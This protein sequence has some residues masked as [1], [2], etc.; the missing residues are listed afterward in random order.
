M[1]VETLRPVSGF[2]TGL[3]LFPDTGEANW[4]DV[5]EVTPDDDTTYV[6]KGA[7]AATA[8]D[9][10]N[11]SNSGVGA[12]VITNVRVY[13]RVKLEDDEEFE[14][15]GEI[16]IATHSTSYSSGA[17]TQSNVWATRYYD[18]AINPNTS[19][20]WTWVEIDALRAGVLLTSI[21]GAEDILKAYCTQFYVVVTYEP[22]PPKL[23]RFEKY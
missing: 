23:R 22:I 1:A 12:G 9:W 19:Q 2:V 17:V 7:P 5:D 11:L 4:E 8:R 15:S 3:D 16:E 21:V 10:Y 20:P 18:W 14:S 6:F 13:A